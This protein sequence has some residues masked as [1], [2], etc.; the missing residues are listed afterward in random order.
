MLNTRD[1]KPA[2]KI[3]SFTFCEDKTTV[4]HAESDLKKKKKK[5][6]H[7]IPEDHSGEKSK[8]STGGKTIPG[9]EGKEPPHTHCDPYPRT[10]PMLHSVVQCKAMA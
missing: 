6:N 7:V 3:S 10:V 8:N 1:I 4:N 9:L 5:E 2:I